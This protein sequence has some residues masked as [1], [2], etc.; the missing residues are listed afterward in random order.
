MVFS[1]Y[2]FCFLNLFVPQQEKSFT[3]KFVC[4]VFIDK[5]NPQNWINVKRWWW[6]GEDFEQFLEVWSMFIFKI[7]NTNAW[8]FTR[9]RIVY[10]KFTPI[11]G[12][13]AKLRSKHFLLSTLNSPA[14]KSVFD[15]NKN[16]LSEWRFLFDC[17]FF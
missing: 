14:A 10:F 17:N 1:S 4:S 5:N 12:I 11:R 16:M 3:P 2:S 15:W 9:L 8:E 13:F 6:Q 7:L